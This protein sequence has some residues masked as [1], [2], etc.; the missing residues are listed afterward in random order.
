MLFGSALMFLSDVMV[1]VMGATCWVTVWTFVVA[2][3]FMV[4]VVV[5]LF[6][7]EASVVCWTVSV[8]GARTYATTTLVKVLVE[9]GTASTKAVEGSP[10][11]VVV[12]FSAPCSIVVC[13]VCVWTTPLIVRV[14]TTVVV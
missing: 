2:G 3:S 1:S 14:M 5:T 10:R 7:T 9:E 12:V 6:W 11:T 13:T 4:A 8:G